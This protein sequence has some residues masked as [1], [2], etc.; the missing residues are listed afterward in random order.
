MNL[1]NEGPVPTLKV[2]LSSTSLDLKQY[3]VAARRAIEELEL[4][5]ESMENWSAATPP[6]VR[7]CED[8]VRRC[9]ILVG[10]LGHV[11]GSSPKDTQKSFTEV[12]Y[13]VAQRA[14]I[15]CLMFMATEK[16]SVPGDVRSTDRDHQRQLE[17]RARVRQESTIKMFSSPLQLK[18]LVKAAL[19]DHMRGSASPGPATTARR[20]SA[21]SPVGENKPRS[22]IGFMRRR[23]RVIL[24]GTATFQRLTNG[25]IECRAKPEKY[26]DLFR[27]ARLLRSS[28]EQSLLHAI[29]LEDQGRIADALEAID[30]VR[31]VGEE[32]ASRR[33]LRA[34]LLDK[35]DRLNEALGELSES[36]RLT[37][38][39]H[40]QIAAQFN[41]NVCHEKMD[42]F[43]HVDF[44]RYLNDRRYRL[45]NKEYLWCKALSNHLILCTRAGRPFRYRDLVKDALKIEVQGSPAGYVKTIVNWLRYRRRRLTQKRFDKLRLLE[46]SMSITQRA[47]LLHQLGDERFFQSDAELHA[48]L[49]KSL[50]H[51]RRSSESE[52]VRKFGQ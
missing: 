3:R 36:L 49:K 10:I 33:L 8:K 12:E 46:V 2:F 11:Y 52:A 21:A 42:E 1:I 15:P 40:I 43:Q 45:P 4:Y 37:K 16:V 29:I 41:A 22:S 27:K 51:L 34:V 24:P 23:C 44:E 32:E 17:F 38:N 48:N 19:V 26:D 5:A 14:A 25:L 7:R 18:D 35:Q 9:D 50:D 6:P 20:P 28:Y 31:L 39:R 47:A 30:G 13:E